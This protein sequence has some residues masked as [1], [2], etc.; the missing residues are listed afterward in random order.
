MNS[1]QKKQRGMKKM[2]HE[3]K[4]E[5]DDALR[6]KNFEEAIRHYSFC[7]N[8][9]NRVGAIKSSRLVVLLG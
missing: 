2:L 1:P 5:G 9:G 4:K 6:S 7:I 3:V 8:A